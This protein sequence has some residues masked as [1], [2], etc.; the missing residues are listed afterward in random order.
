MVSSGIFM[1]SSAHLFAANV[2]AT[3]NTHFQPSNAARVIDRAPRNSLVRKARN[4]NLARPDD[5]SG[6]SPFSPLLC[7]LLLVGAGILVKF[8]PALQSLHLAH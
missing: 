4:S 7:V 3:M 1:R 6:Q 5:G 8:G 2:G